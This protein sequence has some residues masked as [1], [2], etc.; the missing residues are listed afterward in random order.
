MSNDVHLIRDFLS[1]EDFNLIKE[2]VSN[3]NNVSKYPKTYKSELFKLKELNNPLKI[4]FLKVINDLIHE[5]D[6]NITF[7][8][9]INFNAKQN[10]H[11]DK[12]QEAYKRHKIFKSPYRSII[13]YV[14]KP[15]EGG[16]IQLMRTIECEKKLLIDK[17][18]FFENQILSF[19]SSIPHRVCA[20]EGER[21][22]IAINIWKQISCLHFSNTI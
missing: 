20:Y 14:K 7:E 18:D 6:N 17:Y 8:W 12:D 2:W 15:R 10:W 11:I 21:I 13:F 3:K 5:T 9:W 1:E 19:C 16:G 4:L 22:S